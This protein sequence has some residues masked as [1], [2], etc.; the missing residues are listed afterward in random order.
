M[1]IDIY[2]Y[3]V[4]TVCVVCVYN[5]HCCVFPLCLMCV[6]V[7]GELHYGVIVV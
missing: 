5:G 7:V 2:V 3:S 6:I 4:S 1:R